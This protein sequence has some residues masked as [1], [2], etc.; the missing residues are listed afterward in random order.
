ME[1]YHLIK[2]FLIEKKLK[3]KEVAEKMNMHPTLFNNYLNGR[4][5]LS[6]KYLKKICRAL[7]IDFNV[8]LKGEIKEL[9]DQ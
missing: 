1:I 4:F 8:F 3:Q 7:K 9:G 6:E 2:V 5:N